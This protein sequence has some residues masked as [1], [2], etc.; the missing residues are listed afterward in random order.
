MPAA[1]FLHA[2]HALKVQT[3]VILRQLAYADDW[4]PT[5]STRI[6]AYRYGMLQEHSPRNVAAFLAQQLTRAEPVVSQP[7]QAA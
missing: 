7:F 5:H 2:S 4:F 1:T 6:I 3:R